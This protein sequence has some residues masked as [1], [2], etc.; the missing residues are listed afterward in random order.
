MLLL[1]LC[2]CSRR[3]VQSMDTAE[4]GS[5]REKLLLWSYYETEA[6]KAGLN[7]LMEEFNQSQTQYE[8]CWEYVPMQDYVKRLSA[9]VSEQ[10]LP[11]LVLLDNPDTQSLINSG[12]LEDITEY[13]PDKVKNDTYYYEVYKTVTQKSR[14]YG[15]PFSC[16]N[17]ALIYNKEM[18][19]EAGVNEPSTWEELVEASKKLTRKG[20]NGH[21][22]FAMS[23]TGGEQGAFQFMP[24]LLATGVDKEHMDDLS[25]KEAFERLDEMLSYGSMPYECLN[26]SQ[27]D[28]T[29][30][31]LSGQVAM[32]ENGPWAIPKL[33]EA[34]MD[35]G[36]CPIPEYSKNGVVFGGENLAL[37]QG[38][39]KAGGIAVATFCTR[40]DIMA[41]V[42]ELTGNISPIIENARRFGRSYPQYQVF[43]DQMECGISR[44][45]IP[46][47]KRVCQAIN[48]SFCLLFG[49]EHTTEQVFNEYVLSVAGY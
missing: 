45:D 20:K 12:F 46:N 38:K 26:W 21:Y 35:Y 37:I 32:I 27:N 49:S 14:I 43:V 23:A 18:F 10:N 39:N 15:I 36:I 42:G 40:P 41:R 2:G 48:D 11:D 9:V 8:L 28:L 13:I 22:G 25:A 33:E 3:P 29:R 1:L 31:F 4:A 6:Q 16:N 30:M 47:W 24:W 19:K 44:S 5:E 34:K 7:Y 17:V